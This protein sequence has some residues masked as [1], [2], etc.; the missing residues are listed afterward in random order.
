M[1]NGGDNPNTTSDKRSRRVKATPDLTESKAAALTTGAAPPG[2]PVITVT[3]RHP[4]G[5]Y[6]RYE[7]DERR[8]LLYL[9]ERVW[10]EKHNSFE[11]GTIP[12]TLT[13]R[14][15]ELPAL[16]P[17]DLPDFP[18]VV[19]KARP[20]GLLNEVINPDIGERRPQV[21]NRQFIV[22]VP[23][24]DPLYG[25]ASKVSD[26]SP[27]WQMEVEASLTTNSHDEGALTSREHKSNEGSSRGQLYE[28]RWESGEA[29]YKVIAHSRQAFR[30]AHSNLSRPDWKLADEELDNFLQGD[31]L[32]EDETARHS[33]AENEFFR[34]PYRFQEHVA[35]CLLPE[36]R[37]VSWLLRPGFKEGFLWRKVEHQD[38]LLI[39]TDRQLL[40]LSDTLPP[41]STLVDWGY[42][43]EAFSLHRLVEVGIT[44][45]L[46]SFKTGRNSLQLRV[47]WAAGKADT[48]S[49]STRFKFNISNLH[50]A[51]GSTSRPAS[52]PL[53]EQDLEALVGRLAK[54]VP[55]KTAHSL[56]RLYRFK[57]PAPQTETKPGGRAIS[58]PAGTPEF[59]YK[60]GAKSTEN[61]EHE[62]PDKLH[63]WLVGH[64]YKLLIEPA[65]TRYYT[66]YEPE[67]EPGFAALVVPGTSQQD[68]GSDYVTGITEAVKVS[69]GVANAAGDLFFELENVTD[70]KDSQAGF[71]SCSPEAVLLLYAGMSPAKLKSANQAAGRF[72]EQPDK[73][74]S[75]RS[76][77]HAGTPIQAYPI[78]SIYS[79]ELLYSILGCYLNVT[80][81]HGAEV[82]TNPAAELDR[83][84]KTDL[85]QKEKTPY[86]LY[87]NSPEGPSFQ[88][89][90]LALRQLLDICV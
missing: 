82:N 17:V 33:E 31:L 15:V 73:G 23:L 25:G 48:C 4:S 76:K 11:V 32:K 41:G 65:L 1:K 80:V 67:D 47:S 14:G 39:Q 40:W 34:L 7:W 29:A 36:E 5:S 30:S 83:L 87:F 3:I 38:A 42:R 57:V 72:K 50:S 35:R 9:A 49:L 13:W 60:S 26:L 68:A 20:I 54:F 24:A 43:V 52:L 19:V 45:S 58:P 53:L 71:G 59:S 88:A 89:L 28:W 84:D 70:G 77:L 22:A 90:F 78:K 56:L 51:R 61:A 75:A 6:N 85:D 66:S 27:S 79:V 86:R 63:E 46:S 18:D 64:H 74:R 69:T 2:F 55:D 16:L 37:I 21:M 62:I 12:G 81:A 10:L 44:N 8:G